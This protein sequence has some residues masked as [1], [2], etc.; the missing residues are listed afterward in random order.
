MNAIAHIKT[1]INKRLIIILIKFLTIHAS[2]ISPRSTFTYRKRISNGFHLLYIYDPLLRWHLCRAQTAQD[3]F[4]WCHVEML[5]RIHVHLLANLT[6]FIFM[7]ICRKRICKH[8]KSPK[9]RN[10]VRLHFKTIQSILYKESLLGIYAKIKTY[11]GIE[12][13]LSLCTI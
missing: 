7:S 9:N 12:K 10:F 2:L 13:F 11:F 3:L 1:T 5:T 8:F 6:T 4:T